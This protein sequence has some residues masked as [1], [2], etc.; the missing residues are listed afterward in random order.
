MTREYQKFRRVGIAGITQ[1]IRSRLHGDYPQ[2]SVAK[3]LASP[4]PHNKPNPHR[5]EE[6][7]IGVATI[8]VLEGVIAGGDLFRSPLWALKAQR[9]TRILSPQATLTGN[10]VRLC[11][12]INTPG[13]FHTPPHLTSVAERGSAEGCNTRL[14]IIANGSAAWWL[15]NKPPDPTLT[16]VDRRGLAASVAPDALQTWPQITTNNAIRTLPRSDATL[17]YRGFHRGTARYV[18]AVL[19]APHP[20]GRRLDRGVVA[21]HWTPF[22]RNN[23]AHNVSLP[24]YNIVTK[25][26]FQLL[27]TSTDCWPRFKTFGLVLWFRS[28]SRAVFF[29]IHP[30]PADGEQQKGGADVEKVLYDSGFGTTHERDVDLQLFSDVHGDA[31]Y[32]FRTRKCL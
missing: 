29:F 14:Y 23:P 21:L 18:G 16:V 7:A 3:Y 2:E 24:V 12:N 4:R 32:L 30:S 9:V 20:V 5:G 17:E 8:K 10:S 25:A 22:V 13:N 28:S 6:D 1:K 31:Y 15:T 27:A 19:D 11:T 26:P